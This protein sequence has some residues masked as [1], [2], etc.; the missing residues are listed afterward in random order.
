MA[1]LMPDPAVALSLNLKKHSSVIKSKHLDHLISQMV[2]IQLNIIYKIKNYR[3][4]QIETYKIT[5]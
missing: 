2:S 1:R 4:L 5:Q 3:Q